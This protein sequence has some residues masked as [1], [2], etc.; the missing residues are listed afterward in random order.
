M[1]GWEGPSDCGVSGQGEHSENL[2]N[3][4][5]ESVIPNTLSSLER[6]DFLADGFVPC[7]VEG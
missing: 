4:S 3:S 6:V 7:L 2:D 5:C 1:S